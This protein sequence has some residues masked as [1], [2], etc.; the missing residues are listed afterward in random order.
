M[1]K[2]SK[3]GGGKQLDWQNVAVSMSTYASFGKIGIVFKLI[4][5]L[6]INNAAV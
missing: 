1:I 3:G 2:I 5:K 6:L 4:E